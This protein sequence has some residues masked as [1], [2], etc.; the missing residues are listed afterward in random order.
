MKRLLLIAIVLIA[1]SLNAQITGLENLNYSLEIT[2]F[3][4]SQENPINVMGV[5]TWINDHE[6]EWH[7]EFGY[8]TVAEI[9]V[10][11]QMPFVFYLP[12]VM[13]VTIPAHQSYTCNVSYSGDVIMSAGD[14]LARAH[15]VDLAHTPL[16]NPVPFTTGPSS[17]QDEQLALRTSSVYPNPFTSSTN[18]SISATKAA[19]A[20]VSIYNLKGQKV[21]DLPDITLS[22]GVNQIN[23]QAVDAAGKLLPSGIYLIKIVSEGESR[24]TR[25]MILK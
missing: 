14:H 23:W 10:D 5:L 16:G 4:P 6:Q 18:I 1:F 19:P 11:G 15:A 12:I 9:W 2:G 3:F 17:T 20:R 8:S 24:L 13:S 22:A 25:A 21:Q 7:M